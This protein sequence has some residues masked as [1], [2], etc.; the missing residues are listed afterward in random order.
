[1]LATTSS[2]TAISKMR[3]A[4]GDIAELK[5]VGRRP[6]KLWFKTLFK[7]ADQAFRPLPGLVAPVFALLSV[8]VALGDQPR[9]GVFAIG[10][11][12]I[13]AIAGI[14]FLIALEPAT[15]PRMVGALGAV[16]TTAQLVFALIALVVFALVLTTESGALQAPR[17]LCGWWCWA[18][19]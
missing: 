13:V 18:L 16:L 1:M 3:C 10:F 14:G 6:L 4:A 2:S 11:A 9:I 17:T 5:N 7:A 19:S 8:A 12:V 15:L